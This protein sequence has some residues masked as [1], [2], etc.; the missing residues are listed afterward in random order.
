MYFITH[1][2]ETIILLII[3]ALLSYMI[4]LT[5]GIKEKFE[6][7]HKKKTKKTNETNKIR[8][9]G[10]DCSSTVVPIYSNIGIVN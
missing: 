8:H 6:I 2:K 10:G 1:N 4:Y 7:V 5:V 3:I 9:C